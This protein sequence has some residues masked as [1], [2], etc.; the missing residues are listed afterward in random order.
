MS[1]QQLGSL[2]TVDARKIWPDEAR[3]FTPW[4]ADNLGL[5]GK[6][7]RM[8]L[9]LVGQEE[10]V[11]RFSL[12]IKAQDVGRGVVVAVENQLNWSD[13]THLGQLLTYAAGVD[14]RVLV[15]VA[16]ELLDE[17]RAALD[18]LN[19]WT[20]EEIEVYGVEVRVVRIGESLPA[21][22]FRPVVVPKT[23]PEGKPGSLLPQSQAYRDF[24]QPLVDEF[25]RTGFTD[26]TT[27]Y[28]LNYQPIRSDLR[29]IDYRASLE[30][31]RRAWVY[32]MIHGSD[33]DLNKRIFD[34]L[35]RFR[36]EIERDL[37]AELD[38]LRNDNKSWS[39]VGLFRD[40][41]LDDPADKHDE[42][43][44]WMLDCLPRLKCAINPRLE[45]VLRGLQPSEA[46][47]N[48][49]ESPRDADLDP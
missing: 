17:H 16:P 1:T 5:L 19:Q 37:N 25:R 36:S 22:D 23:R 27:A 4:L 31:G 30:V 48:A 8:N 18:W 33:Q 34:A 38:W 2:N 46:Q 15:W 3:D 43:R 42:I 26:R 21:P 14:A 9:K 20:G 49:Q 47:P 12:D 28:A 7:L 41:A 13:H 44:A 24:F 11:G 10:Q 32:L 39:S 40:G 45:E 35:H 6:A 29:D